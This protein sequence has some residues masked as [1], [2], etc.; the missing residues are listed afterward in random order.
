[1]NGHGVSQSYYDEQVARNAALKGELERL[2]GE[3]AAIKALLREALLYMDNG[4]LETKISAAL[5]D[6]QAPSDCGEK[7]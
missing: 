2:R 1:M 5:S 6:D 3:L 4:E 7:P